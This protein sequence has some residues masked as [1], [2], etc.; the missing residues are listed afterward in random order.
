MMNQTTPQVNSITL[1][2]LRMSFIQFMPAL[3]LLHAKKPPQIACPF[4]LNDVDFQ[5]E[6]SKALAGGTT[7]RTPWR[8]GYGKLFWFRYLPKSRSP[9][10]MWRALV[11]LDYDLAPYISS[12]TLN[13][14]I[15][16]VGAYLYP[17]G[18][19]TIVD[20][21][22]Q[23][24]LDL[25]AAVRRAL[26]I[27]TKARIE[28]KF[29]TKSG[30]SSPTG[31]AD[32][33]RERLGTVLYNETLA[34]E[35]PSELFSV[36]TVTD[37]TGVTPT[38]PIVETKEIH[39]SLEALAGWNQSWEYMDLKP[40]ADGKI[41][42]RQLAAGAMLYGRSRGRVGWFPDN[43][44]SVA[45][46]PDRLSCYH[47]NLT[48]CSLHVESLC[49]L[50]QDAAA[51]LRNNGSLASFSDN[52]RRCAQLAAGRLGKLHGKKTDETK[53]AKPQTYRSG[54]IRA[55]IQLYKDDINRLRL[56]YPDMKTALDT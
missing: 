48:M 49:A 2:E 30:T 54:S 19:G 9:Y 47:Q 55:Q 25:Y 16:A 46:Y 26:E 33:L 15:V 4:L 17:W 42:T 31:L 35:N 37:A 41:S 45:S 51:E 22:L 50:A 32:A 23:K 56:I 34:P 21:T 27:K 29:D 53:E 3:A 7:F 13:D 14:C 12:L 6:L 43:F 39:R 11:P 36:V 10:E 1:N 24:P 28:W 20:V 52:Y 5:T 38:D 18:M 8:D 44:R 40:L